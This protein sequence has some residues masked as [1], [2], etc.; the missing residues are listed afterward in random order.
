MKAVI[1]AKNSSTRVPGKNFR[2]FHE[3]RSLFE[4]K[5]A[6]LLRHMP[7]ESIYVSSEDPAVAEHASKCGVNFL[8]RNPYLAR[9]DTPFAYVVSE[10]CRQVPGDDDIAW[11]HVT[12]PL[13][14]DFKSCLELWNEA[15]ETYDSLAVVYPLKGYLLDADHRPMGFGFGP[16]HVPSQFLPTRY[17]LGFTLSLLHRSTAVSLGPIG[18]KTCWFHARNRMV[19]IDEEDDFTMAQI[20]YGRLARDPG[21]FTGEFAAGAWTKETRTEESARL[22]ARVHSYSDGRRTNA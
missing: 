15:R 5:V 18:A 7:S 16:W 17:Q 14:D 10:I 20:I 22:E 1:P 19:D 8:L 3:G 2:P 12:D 6:Q 4:I 9:N 13:F 11:C 21:G